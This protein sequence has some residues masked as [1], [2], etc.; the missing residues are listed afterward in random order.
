MSTYYCSRLAACGACF[1]EHRVK[2]SDLN[3]FPASALR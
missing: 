3:Q 2:N 1:P